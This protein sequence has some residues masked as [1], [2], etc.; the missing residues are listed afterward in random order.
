MTGV[1]GGADA[2]CLPL[3][4][5]TRK[6]VEGNKS[7]AFRT[8]G[9]ETRSAGQPFGVSLILDWQRGELGARISRARDRLQCPGGFGLPNS[10][11]MSKSGNFPALAVVQYGDVFDEVSALP[12]DP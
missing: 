1:R 2:Y 8:T 11:R 3:P 6:P 5:I 9:T 12:R 4:H 7:F 10:N